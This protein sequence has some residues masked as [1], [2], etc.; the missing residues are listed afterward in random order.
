MNIYSVCRT[1]FSAAAKRALLCARLALSLSAEARA[2]RRTSTSLSARASGSDSRLFSA[3]ISYL[4]QRMGSYVS[5]AAAYLTAQPCFAC[6]SSCIACMQSEV[7]NCTQ[8][9]HC[10]RPYQHL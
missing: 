7:S 6:R 10:C 1:C 4:Q 8:D 5:Q 3:A 2:A 9:H